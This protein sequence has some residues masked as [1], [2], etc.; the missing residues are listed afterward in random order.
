MSF[1]P[2]FI[3][4]IKK[5]LSI[6]AV[7]SRYVAIQRRGSRLVGLCPFHK[8]KTPSFYIFEQDDT[9]H[10]FGCKAHGDIFDFVI[11]LKGFDFPTTAEFL[12][13]EAG[14]AIPQ[15][16]KQVDSAVSQEK[17]LQYEIMS[18]AC[19]FYEQQLKM[20]MGHKARK[21]LSERGIK[22]EMIQR[23]NL[24]YAT[25]GHT[26]KD[27]LLAKGFTLE[28]LQKLH[29]VTRTGDYDFFRQRL[30]FPI[31]NKQGKIVAFGG[32]S[33]DGSDPKYLNSSETPIF[34][35]SENLYGYLQSR[36]CSDR[37]KPLIICEGYLDVISLHQAGFDKATAPLG[38]ALGEGQIELAWRLYPTPII[39]FDGDQAGK[40]A[41]LSALER[42]LPVLKPGYSLQFVELPVGEDPDSLIRQGRSNVLA[43]IFFKPDTLT[44]K[45]WNCLTQQIPLETPEQQAFFKDK[46]MQKL[47]VIKHFDIKKSYQDVL[48]SEFYRAIRRVNRGY[49]DEKRKSLIKSSNRQKISAD[50]IR[51][52]LL[53]ALPLYHPQILEQIYEPLLGFDFS[54]ARFNSLK[55]TMISYVTE[56]KLLDRD[57]FH[58]HLILEGY[59]DLLNELFAKNLRIHDKCLDFCVII[60]DVVEQWFF[61]YHIFAEQIAKEEERVR[62]FDQIR[63]QLSVPSQIEEGDCGNEIN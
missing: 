43:Q 39:C 47:N 56:Q 27:H 4:T 34:Q 59:K 44:T 42:S 5:K 25:G 45:L 62:R 2:E 22:P 52:K 6:Q 32:R 31:T 15:D 55:E 38:T 63:Q 13:N 54:D 29:L 17:K 12:A 18:I 24:G 57:A 35:K 3:D 61:H 10:C 23:F 9:Y 14:I 60:E 46:L 8:E 41:A 26:L 21:Y 49:A 11:A 20:D 28:Q 58:T 16:A 53:L 7:V 51:Q 19:A 37:D 30:I 33:L 50:S 48:L 1:S 36:N 40:R